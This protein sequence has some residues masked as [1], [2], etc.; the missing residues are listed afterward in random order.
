MCS[1][2]TA[3]TSARLVQGWATE[4]VMAAAGLMAAA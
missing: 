4:A 1:R 3:N 2:S